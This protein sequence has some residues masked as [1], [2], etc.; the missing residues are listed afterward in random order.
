[1]RHEF[2][3]VRQTTKATDVAFPRDATIVAGKDALQGVVYVSSPHQ[4]SARVTGPHDELVR[5]LLERS[6][7]DSATFAWNGL[8]DRNAPVEDGTYYLDVVSLAAPDVPLRTLRIPLRV[9]SFRSDTLALPPSRPPASLLRPEK[10]GAGPALAYLLPGIAVGAALIGPAAT[11]S[12]GSTGLR[13][14]AGGLAL[15][16][17]TVGYLLNR[18]G[19]P[20]PANVA[21]NDSIRAT[22]AVTLA[23]AR[24][25][26]AA[27]RATVR[28]AIRAGEPERSEAH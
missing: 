2:A 7:D 14:A 10:T 19:R 21:A 23:R 27:R 22:W 8:D 12:G 15:G 16:I 26:N 9:T 24:A 11:G 13:I 4:V 17:G 28:L 25:V 3:S 1:M 5:T 6:V 20:I 18:P